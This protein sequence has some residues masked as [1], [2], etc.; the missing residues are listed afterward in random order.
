PVTYSVLN[1]HICNSR[2]NVG[3]RESVAGLYTFKH[4]TYHYFWCNF[5]FLKIELKNY[6][7]TTT[8]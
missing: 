8:Y 7:L 4:L 1:I 5:F 3:A 2:E 6:M